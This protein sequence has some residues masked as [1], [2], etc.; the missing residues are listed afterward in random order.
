MGA[1]I[2]LSNTYHLQMRPGSDLIR[3]AGGLHAFMR[4]PGAVLTDSGG[5]QVFSL[6]GTRKVTEDGVEFQ[7]HINGSRHF[8]TPEYAI[9]VENNLGADIIMAFDECSAH[10]AD[11][12]YATAAMERTHRWAARCQTAHKREDQALFGIVQGGM[13]DDLR[14]CSA[15]TIDAMGFP[16]NAIG[17]LS[18][19]EEKPLMYHL[20]EQTTV[21]LDPQRPR[22]LMG[23]GSPDCLINGVLRGV[24][25]FDL[26]LIHI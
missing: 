12:A 8:F 5:F 20:L 19:G 18:V 24:D 1:R 17:G 9:E 22:Y 13:F 25:M 2:I 7:S 26:S 21:H 4:W 11:H 16:G 10:T 14:A 6:S 3:Q 15:K 23:V